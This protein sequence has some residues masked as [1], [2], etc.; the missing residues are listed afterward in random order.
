MAVSGTTLVVKKNR[1]REGALAPANS[2]PRLAKRGRRLH[3]RSGRFLRDAWDRRIVHAP[4]LP[5]R[6]KPP[7]RLLSTPRASSPTSRSPRVV[8]TP[9][10]SVYRQPCAWKSF[11][12]GAS[13]PWSPKPSNFLVARGVREIALSSVR[14]PPATAKIAGLRDNPGDTA[15]RRSPAFRI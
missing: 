11:R 8:T 13:N 5:L 15:R 7:S 12:S 2:R 6:Q 14:T 3:E 1:E 10:P 9:A 4:N